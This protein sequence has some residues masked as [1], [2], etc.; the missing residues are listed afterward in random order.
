MQKRIFDS[1]IC[2]T[3]IQ[4]STGIAFQRGGPWRHSFVV[5]V[6][7]S[8]LP[9]FPARCWLLTDLDFRD[10]FSPSLP[11]SL[12]WGAIHSHLERK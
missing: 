10:P 8:F 11:P 12:P 1:H 9:S 5:L 6:P 7:S 2:L 4:L 3:R